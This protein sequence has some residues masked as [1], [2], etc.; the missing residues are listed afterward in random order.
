[1]AAVQSAEWQKAFTATKDAEDSGKFRVCISSERVDRHGEVIDQK[2]MNVQEYMLNP[3]V[4]AQHD[5]RALPIGICDRLE[6]VESDDGKGGRILKTFAE[7]RFVPASAN[8][9][10]Q[11]YRQLY[12]LGAI[13]TT[14][15]GIMVNEMV[16]T[17]ITKSE[18]LEFSFVNIPANPDARRRAEERGID[19]S[20][21]QVKAFGSVV[22]EGDV[23]TTEKGE[24]ADEVERQAERDKK[25][26][27][28]A[29]LWDLLDAAWGVYFDDATSS[30]DFTTVMSELADLI[31]SLGT[32]EKSAVVMAKLAEALKAGTF[33]GTLVR[34]TAK[35]QDKLNTEVGQVMMQ[36]QGLLVSETAD[37]SAKIQKL[38]DADEAVEPGE[39]EP[40]TE[41]PAA[42]DTNADKSGS[43]G[44]AEPG[45]ETA[46]TAPAAAP[47]AKGRKGAPVKDADLE[48]LNKHLEDR[49]FQ[50]LLKQINR[51]TSVALEGY[52]RRAKTANK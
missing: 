5:W 51:V 20:A 4:L 21:L 39:T 37:A 24:V 42:D 6:T 23:E 45:S 27:N 16:D 3:I 9:V 44:T 49:N 50:E 38:I 41:A 7:G 32:V 40:V 19:L 11:N 36:L 13:N 33:K 8:P 1:M 48:G 18:L 15:V 35:A 14:S 34:R 2:G 10:A 47:A 29:Q 31:K 17:R 52:N 46:P 25:W 30:G 26:K 12:D 22:K 28:W 43:D